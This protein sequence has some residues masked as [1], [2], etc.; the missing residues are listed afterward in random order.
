M[1]QNN[2]SNLS[3]LADLDSTT[4]LDV[5]S[6]GQLLTV[7]RVVNAA[8]TAGKPAAAGDAGDEQAAPVES[9]S[10]EQAPI[11]TSS[12]G[13]QAPPESP[14]QERAKATP[15]LPIKGRQSLPPQPQP[16][17]AQ[18]S[19]SP[20]GQFDFSDSGTLLAMLV[21]MICIPSYLILFPS[22]AEP[23]TDVLPTA[24]NSAPDG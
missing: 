5:G 3:L 2:H 18:K 1:T 12:E 20:P 17:A 15:G 22:V 7:K 13:E 21:N 9:S 11:E 8:A 6:S 10:G 14:A 16:A 23:E 4:L 19:P 24:Q